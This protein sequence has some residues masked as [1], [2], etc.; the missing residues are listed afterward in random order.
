M[1]KKK[2]KVIDNRLREGL[3]Q[4][5]FINQSMNLSLLISHRLHKPAAERSRSSHTEPML[6]QV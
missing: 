2:K 1:S 5:H 3:F 4:R 6:L